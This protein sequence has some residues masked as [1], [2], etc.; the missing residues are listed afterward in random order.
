MGR[1]VGRGGLLAGLRRWGEGRAAGVVPGSSFYYWGAV[2]DY[3]QILLVGGF[4]LSWFHVV[5]LDSSMVL[6]L[7]LLIS[8]SPVQLNV[9]L[10]LRSKTIGKPSRSNQEPLGAQ[11]NPVSGKGSVLEE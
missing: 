6:N 2:P 11:L 1:T 10:G 3:Y 7:L 4:V 5:V 9:A 8:R